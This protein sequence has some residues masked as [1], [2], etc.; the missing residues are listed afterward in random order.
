VGYQDVKFE[1]ETKRSGLI[2]LYTDMQ[3]YIHESGLDIFDSRAPGAPCSSNR[4]VVA[5]KME[6]QKMVH[7]YAMPW[8]KVKK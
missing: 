8:R 4:Q 7:L 6:N 2:N 3:V 5:R 1:S